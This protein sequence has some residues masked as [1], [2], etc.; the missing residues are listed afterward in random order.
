MYALFL[1]DHEV[2]ARIGVHDF[3]QTAPQRLMVNVSLAIR[4]TPEGDDLADTTDYDF[5]RRTT[6]AIIE[7]GHIGL[8]ETICTKLLDACRAQWKSFGMTDAG[9]FTST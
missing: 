1:T 6:A 5:L 4:G 7:Q 2:R 8:Q 9:S 3:E